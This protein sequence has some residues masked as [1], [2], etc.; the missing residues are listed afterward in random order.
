MVASWLEKP[1]SLEDT[2]SDEPAASM[3]G[4]F[5]LPEDGGNRFLQTSDTFLPDYTL[6]EA[7]LQ[8][9]LRCEP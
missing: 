8:G 9:I 3:I 4:T 6:L 1:C 7:P 2:F 5:F